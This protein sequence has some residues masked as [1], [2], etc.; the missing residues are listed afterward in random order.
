MPM[1]YV[2]RVELSRFKSFGG[3]SS[4]PFLPGFTVISGP[5]GSGKS[6][7]LDGILFCLG[8]A[9]SKGMR[10][11]RLP[12][13][14]NNNHHNNGRT[15][16]ATVSVTFDISDL[17]EVDLSSVADPDTDLENDSSSGI[18]L[19]NL[20][21]FKVTRRLKVT[22]GGNYTSTFYLNDTPCTAS[23]LHTQLNRLR[24]YPEGYNIVLQGD[25]T[26]IITMNSRERR[27]IIDELAGVAE[28]D[29]KIEQ[30]RKTLD[31]VKE[32]EERCHI[33]EQEL[34]K[35]S[36]RLKLDS[37]K[38]EK[39]RK[40]KAKI[41]EK[42]QWEIV[43]QWR[44]KQ[45]EK[46]NLQKA[47]AAMETET[48]QLQ[49][50]LTTIAS[51]IDQAT[52]EINQLNHQVK[53]L[54]EEEQISIAS[55]LATQ[56]AKRQ[57]L[58]QQQQEL[59]NHYQQLTSS[60]TQIQSQIE[61]D[62]QNLDTLE[63]EKLSLERDTIPKLIAQ[64]EEAKNNL[65]TT[66]EKAQ[67]IASQS[68][69]WVEK[70]TN[71]S[72]D[73]AQIQKNL[74]P[75]LTQQ[76]LLNERYQQLQNI[77]EAENQQLAT[78][79]IEISTK[80][81]D[82][83][84]LTLALKNAE[85]EIQLLGQQLS[86]T[87]TDISVSQETVSRLLN[88]QREKQRKLDKLEAT[89]QAQQEVQ[90]TYATKI[91]L[92]SDLPAVCGLVAQLGQVEPIYQLA[93][94]IAAGGRL[95]F[96][97]VE[98]ET[99]ASAGIQLLKQQRAGRAT[100][101]PLNKIQAPRFNDTVALRYASGFVDLAI[102][103]VNCEPRY[104][105]LFAYVF[106]ST[107]VFEN[108]DYARPY[109]GKHRIVTLEGDLLEISGAMTGGSI[110][111]PASLHFG[112]VKSGDYGEIKT[113]RDRLREIEDTMLHLSGKIA[114]KRTFVKD[115]TENLHQW[116]Q[117]RQKKQ[118]ILEQDRKEL[119]RLEKQKEELTA[120]VANNY[121]NI[122]ASK[123][124][125]ETLGR[126]IPILQTNLLEK[127]EELT[128]LEA[129]N[130][131]QEWQEIQ[132]EITAQESALEKQKET[133]R[134]EQ[135]KLQE[136]INKS[137]HKNEK[138]TQNQEKLREN[139]QQ[140]QDIINQQEK[141]K[142]ELEETEENI[143][144]NNQLFQEL[145]AKLEKIKSQRDEAENKLKTIQNQEQKT[146]WQ[147]QKLADKQQEKKEILVNLTIEIEE[148]NRELPNNLP[149]IPFLVN[150]LDGETETENQA[151]TF[152]NFQ[153]QL[154]HLQKEIRNGQKRLEAMEPVNMLALEEYE[155]NQQRLE[156]LSEKLTTLKGERTELLM[157]VENFT[158][159]RFR[160]FKE[161]YNAVNE[162]FKTIF[163]TLSEGDGYLQLEDEEN[164]FN[165]GLNLIAHPK[166]KPIQRLSSMS[167]GEK[168]LT[169][170]SFIFALQRYRPSPFY[171][172]DEVDM[173]LD[174]ANVE[175][176]AK[177]IRKQS[178]QAQFIVVSLRRPMIEASQR[179]IGVT[180]ARG[181][182]TQV[183]GIKL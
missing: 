42:Q 52:A 21:E 179:T 78:I 37:Q 20:S 63:G 25:V 47:I 171:G 77:M 107:V 55:K 144:T 100:F 109:L 76:A 8:L 93:L 9:S 75:K 162:N 146:S 74:N 121:Q 6:N 118:L 175:K 101:L 44:Y 105:K 59:I 154:D 124:E 142:I 169:A 39:Y 27:E 89:K 86:N 130:S 182:Y 114:E 51:M 80:Q 156:E 19:Q 53:E 48:T 11:E 56:K 115:L 98:D 66:K 174:G 7:I 111:S 132:A 172:F 4:I 117:K 151:I 30:T 183:L 72:R 168:S 94:E 170:L 155:K 180:Q 165:G 49:E 61:E 149:E 164:P 152:A 54:G 46:E 79:N 140:Q 15:V 176:L 138:I 23:D 17:A 81:E 2:K 62:R 28:F 92:Q 139:K 43:L 157:R 141:I 32:R 91:I 84:N 73:I 137:W 122:V 178:Q 38:A 99:V 57:Q 50:Q 129:S 102:N 131:N 163:A 71:L 64:V 34:L 112:A 181:A 110:S 103:L 116:Q 29:R 26:R 5:N 16:E 10:A 87:E 106:G 14:V 125:L 150:D 167:G 135:V 104:E 173:F 97:V 161:A 113:L 145:A 177:M 160:A 153:E 88:E 1:V 133:L 35:N 33:L 24:I 96:I 40:L 3:T 123:Q 136:L 127:Q 18:D 119:N 159:L 67:A 13:L 158:T 58:Q 166:G 120:Q 36:D 60:S 31:A 12:D 22:K 143:A 148:I 95:G 126:D 82:T 45:Q 108:I 128:E 68:Q 147:I 134:N 41:Q 83:I 69:E 65:T 90:G 85:Q 70:Q